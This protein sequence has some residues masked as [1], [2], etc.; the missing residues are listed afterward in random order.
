MTKTYLIHA[1][2]RRGLHQPH[3]HHAFTRPHATQA[4]L[5][6]LSLHSIPAVP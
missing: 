5:V 4:H 3:A 2:S 1:T 6:T